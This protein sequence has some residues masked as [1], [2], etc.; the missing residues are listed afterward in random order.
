MVAN[1]YF[2]LV[3]MPVFRTLALM[4]SPALFK[5]YSAGKYLLF[6]FSW[7]KTEVKQKIPTEKIIFFYVIN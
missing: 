7:E 3:Y 5:T 4:V 1:E 2:L 6:S